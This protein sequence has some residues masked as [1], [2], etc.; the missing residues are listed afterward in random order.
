M[1]FGSYSNNKNANKPYEPDVRCP[2]RFNN[3]E[4]TV[5]KTCLTFGYWK[6]MLK[7]TISPMKENNG[8]EISFDFDNGISVYL[9]SVKARMLAN[10]IDLFILNPD[11]YTGSGLVTGQGV[12]T[13]SNGSEFGVTHPVLV[14]R[15]LDDAGNVI[16]SFAYE[17]KH[18]YYYSIR[19]YSG[20]KEF[21]K[22]TELYNMV[23]VDQMR[24]VLEEYTKAMSYAVAYSVVDA[25]K[26]SN[27]RT[28][29][30]LNSIAEKLGVQVASSSK[31][32][33]FSS[34]TSFFNSASSE[35]TSTENFT[36]ATLD[37]I[38]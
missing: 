34:S 30:T 4:S 36:P 17:F 27:D 23:E 33:R 20:G 16:S 32:S 24:S 14:I 29:K 13:I 8:D 31:G 38:D 5:D 35:S 12:I 11:K 21:S 3:T 2:I 26:F 15:K 22:E 6:Q 10:E 28:Y 1:A 18:D 9:N 25:N 37:D 7:I 19:N